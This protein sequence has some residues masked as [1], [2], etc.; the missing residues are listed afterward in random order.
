MA[1]DE[2]ALRAEIGKRMR[3]ARISVFGD[4]SL[5]VVADRMGVNRSVISRWETGVRS[6]SAVDFVR[7]ARVLSQ[8]P[9]K[10]LAG[11]APARV[12]QLA[13][14]GLDVPATKVVRRLVDL[15]RERRAS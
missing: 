12:S 9:E 7:F 1:D 14:V 11:I 2:P 6:P 3:A 4:N 15:L 13:L 5:G 10:I 8:T